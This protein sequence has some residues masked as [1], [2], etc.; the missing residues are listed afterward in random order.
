MNQ[1]SSVKYGMDELQSAQTF[2]SDIASNKVIIVSVQMG[3]NLKSRFKTFY[4]SLFY[5][6][7]LTLKDKPAFGSI[8]ISETAVKKT[9][10]TL[11][12]LIFQ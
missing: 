11:S 10:R 2:H 9:L 3:A 5:S 4:P 1:K 6:L 12:T 7:H 8:I